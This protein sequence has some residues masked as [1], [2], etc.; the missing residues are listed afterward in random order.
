VR[1]LSDF[2][3]SNTTSSGDDAVATSIGV[4]ITA[5][6]KV[7][8]NL[9]GEQQRSLE[10]GTISMDW[11]SQLVKQGMRALRNQA[12][13]DAWTA[14]SQGASRA[15]GTPGTTPFASDLTALTNARKI[16]QDNG[17][18]LA[19]LYFVGNT[20]AGLNVRNL[21]VFQQAYAAG[22]A[23][24][25]RSGKFQRQYGFVVDESAGVG[26]HT[27]GTGSG[28]LING[29][30]AVGATTIPVNTGT[31][32]IV[33]GDVV[34]IAGDTNMYVVTGALSAGTFT[35]GNPGLRIA[36]S[37]AAAVT[38]KGNFTA[39]VAMERTANVGIMRPP[40]I[41]ANPT[42]HQLP[43]SDPFGMS[44]LMLDIAQY[45]QRS[46]ELHLAWGFKAINSEFSAIV[47][48]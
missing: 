26:L 46:W 45:G 1:A 41:P 28:Y 29:T 6:K 3:P 13:S 8:W 31:G 32:T 42:I 48:G 36:P 38:V 30:P 7:S 2:T 14:V 34:T 16:L 47:M 43:I 27:A 37:N 21:S 22:S 5:S 15:Y 4:Q 12:E 33:A 20:A 25:R 44:Y 10:N 39:N 35:I 40:L 24:E 17:A 19:D 23:E 9:S 18:P 11:V